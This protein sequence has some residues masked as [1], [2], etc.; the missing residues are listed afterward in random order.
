[1][2]ID[3][4]GPQLLCALVAFHGIIDRRAFRGGMQVGAAL[5]LWMHIS[6]EGL[7]FA[8]GLAAIIGSEAVVSRTQADRLTSFASTLASASILLFVGT[9][10]PSAW[11]AIWT[12]AIMPAHLMGFGMAAVV[13]FALHHPAARKASVRLSILAIAGIAA[14]STTLLL[15][16]NILTSPFAALPELVRIFWYENVSEGLPMWE[17][18]SP[19]IF[20][21]VLSPIIGLVGAGAAISNANGATRRAWIVAGAALLVS[22]AIGLWVARAIAVAQLAAIPG[23]VYLLPLGLKRA[24][25]IGSMIPRVLATVAVIMG[26]TP[27]I[28]PQIV[29]QLATSEDFKEGEISEVAA[30]DK[31]G[32]CR[33]KGELAGLAMLPPTRIY[34]PIDMTP[35]TLAYTGHSAIAAPYHRNKAAM[36][37][38]I[39][40]F[41]SKPEDARKSIQARQADL[42]VT[43]LGSAETKNYSR[44]YPD[45]LQARLAEGE[46]PAWLEPV[47][48]PGADREGVLAF[49]V[50]Y[51][52]P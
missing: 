5:A 35:H 45:G 41:I 46:V 38:V 33:T 34:A 27:L 14:A 42:V 22:F 32:T 16:P 52:A 15:Q 37:E 24:R 13:A 30:G 19:D 36:A 25:A 48:L 7:P 3:H 8:V 4:H 39:Q 6:L 29:S 11:S 21:A 9:T 40:T 31:L 10:A 26:L 18:D 20:R 12:D 50:L 43:C 51:D 47:P 44:E 28:I 1:M 23:I 2:R 49:R 17:R